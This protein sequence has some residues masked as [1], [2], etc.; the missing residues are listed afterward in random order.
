MDANLNDMI[1][2]MLSQGKDK[3]REV[4]DLKN[5]L[6]LNER[7]YFMVVVKAFAKIG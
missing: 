3:E 1:V 5:A 7:I 2:A 6:K 4:K